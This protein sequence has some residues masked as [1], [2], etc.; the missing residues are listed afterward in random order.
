[1]V[2]IASAITLLDAE[3]CDTVRKVL[4]HPKFQRLERSFLSIRNLFDA[5]ESVDAGTTKMPDSRRVNV[6]VLD[7]SSD[8][9]RSDLVASSYRRTEVFRKLF[10]QRFDLLIGEKNF[11][12]EGYASVNP[13]SL[14]LVDFEFC[15]PNTTSPETQIG[16]N[17]LRNL[18]RIGQDCFCMFLVG[19]APEFFSTSFHSFGDLTQV[20]DFRKISEK[21][22][23]RAWRDFRSQDESRMVGIALPRVVIREPYE[24]VR[25]RQSGILFN[26][27]ES[28]YRKQDMLWGSAAFAVVQPMIRSFL[29]Y[30]WFAD[31]AGFDRSSA[32]VVYTENI[33]DAKY[34]PGYDGG[35]IKSLP[36]FTFDLDRVSV[37]RYPPVDFTISELDETAFSQLGFISLY[38]VNHSSSVSVLTNQAVQTPIEMTTASASNNFRLSTLFNYMLCVCRMA[39]RLKIECR[40]QIGGAAS[41]KE[42]ENTM[43]AHLMKYTSNRGSQLE[44]R[45]SKPFLNEKTDF[46][47]FEDVTDPGHYDCRISLCPHHKFDNGKTRIVFEPIILEL[48]LDTQDEG[49]S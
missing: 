27:F 34:D 3:L 49:Q 14:I 47:A 19:L 4:H 5:T 16:L 42:F 28:V 21:D 37:S 25:F 41:A 44:Q 46:S 48:P 13:F 30:D 26:E 17:E 32:E 8:E 31:V 43:H 1:M 40:T 2:A 15:F 18:A 23:Y 10:H 33:Y 6:F 39:H 9:L 36:R 24:N 38:A 22:S 12:I 45:M 29:A 7:V 35:L 11:E 20:I